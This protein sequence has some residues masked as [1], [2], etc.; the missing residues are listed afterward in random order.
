MDVIK[1]SLM[2]TKKFA[3]LIITYNEEQHIERCINSIKKISNF[4]LV[5]DSFSID[6]T[7]SLAKKCGATVVSR[8]FLSHSDQINFGIGQLV[9]FD[10][11]LRIDA[12]EILVGGT[13]DLTSC[14]DTA[15]GF[16]LKRNIKFMGDVV[17]YGGVAN[18]KVL[19]LFR[20]RHAHC[21]DVLMDEHILVN[22]DTQNLEAEI[23]DDNLNNFSWWTNKHI[24]YSKKQV[25]DLLDNPKKYSAKSRLDI[26]RGIFIRVYGLFPHRW[27]ALMYFVYRMFLRGGCR[28][29]GNAFYFHVFQAF[30]YRSIIECELENRKKAGL[31]KDS[32]KVRL[33]Y[34]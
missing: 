13:L 28:D 32:G 19:R 7:V 8:K 18:K 12:D 29:K 3:V 20:P 22:G 16:F 1:N 10:L 11:V 31:I 34:F 15:N 26:H 14:L 9:D 33:R 6:K 21:E 17:K 30:W 24:G 27:R 4:T 23:L 25:I 2:K 5:V